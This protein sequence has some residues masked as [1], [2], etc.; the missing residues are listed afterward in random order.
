MKSI[1]NTFLTIFL[2]GIFFLLG[3]Y[4]F[5]RVTP[6][7]ERIICDTLVWVRPSAK[8]TSLPPRF[9]IQKIPLIY[10]D[11]ISKREYIVVNDTVRV[12]VQTPE[13][14]YEWQDSSYYISGRGYHFEMDTISIFE[15]TKI[16]HILYKPK[17]EFEACMGYRLNKNF[18]NVYEFRGTYNFWRN[19]YFNMGL[20][21]GISYYDQELS[22]DI[23]LRINFNIK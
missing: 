12:E 9:N 2:V 6:F 3:R 19:Q 21:G 7:E 20:Q 22:P 16:Q 17:W 1:V 11:T 15:K 4:V 10:F 13:N 14:R 8:I 5:P 18:N 23:R